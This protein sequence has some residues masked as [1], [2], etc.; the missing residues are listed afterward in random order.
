LPPELGV[1]E[2]AELDE[3]ALDEA[4]LDEPAPD[5]PAPE[6]APEEAAEEAGEAALDEADDDPA[7]DAEEEPADELEGPDDAVDPL[8]PQAAR[9]TNAAAARAS[10]KIGR[11]VMIGEL[12]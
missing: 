11:R 2:P 12:L 4:A 5:V 10:P 6:A 7:E 3:P 8:D 1:S 9:D